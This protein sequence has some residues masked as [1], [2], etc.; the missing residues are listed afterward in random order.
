MVMSYRIYAVV[1]CSLLVGGC[2]AVQGG[3][4]AEVGSGTVDAPRLQAAWEKADPF[5]T[6]AERVA[7]RP[8]EPL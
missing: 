1:A 8:V 7:L 3:R 2:A 5:M 6:P 4:R